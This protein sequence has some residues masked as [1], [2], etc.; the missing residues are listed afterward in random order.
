MFGLQPPIDEW[1]EEEAVEPEMIIERLQ[2]LADDSD[3]GEAGGRRAGALERRREAD[4][5]P[6]ARPLLE[7][8]SGDARRA[9]PG[10]PPA[11]LCAEEADRRI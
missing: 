9:A 1:L 7:R 10:D 2:K 8:A 4:P 11:Q 6:D 3:G 5:D